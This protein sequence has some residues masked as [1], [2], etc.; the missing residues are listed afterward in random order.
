MTNKHWWETQ[1]GLNW[2]GVDIIDPKKS[3]GYSVGDKFRVV[4]PDSGAL[5]SVYILAQVG[6]LEV[7]LISLDFGN[8]YRESL[9]V[10]DI[11][12]LLEKEWKVISE[13]S[14]DY[15][16]ERTNDYC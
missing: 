14:E 2:L 13:S 10:E 6:P 15:I 11:Y 8:R 3:T 12:N 4:Y 1:E 5:G 9:I 16:F 7:A